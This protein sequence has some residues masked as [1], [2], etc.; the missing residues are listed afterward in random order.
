MSV[1]NYQRKRGTQFGCAANPM[2]CT[3]HDIALN[4]SRGGCTQWI[5]RESAQSLLPPSLVGLSFKWDCSIP[6]RENELKIQCI[7]LPEWSVSLSFTVWCNTVIVYSFGLAEQP[8]FI[9]LVS[10]SLTIIS[11]YQML[12]DMTAEHPVNEILTIRRYH[13]INCIPYRHSVTRFI[14]V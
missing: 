5:V 6:T 13:M 10:C 8:N 11:W 9:H 4:H 3:S 14:Q 12:V 7:D 2:N 1:G